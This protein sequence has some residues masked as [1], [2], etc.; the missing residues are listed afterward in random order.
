MIFVL[1]V[2]T[3][4][5][6][7]LPGL[8]LAVRERLSIWHWAALATTS[9]VGMMLVAAVV[10]I[11]I[12]RGA[13]AWLPFA[14][15]LPFIALALYAERGKTW[16][17]PA[18]EWQALIAPAV[19]LVISAYTYSRGFAYQ[20]DGS[21]DV[22]SWYNA[23]WFKHLGHVHAVANLGLPARDIFGGGEP[24]HYYWL[25]YVFP[26]AAAAINGDPAGSLYWANMLVVVS[27]WL[28]LHGLVRQTGLSAWKAAILT[29]AAWGLFG[30][31]G[32]MAWLSSGMS[33]FDFAHAIQPAGAPLVPVNLYVPQHVL[34]VS[35]LFAW[36]LLRF[37]PD[38]PES[39]PARWI[40]WA[41][42]IAA[43]TVST[44][45]GVGCLAVYGLAM[46]TTIDRK[47]APTVIGEGAIV[48]VLAI[49]VVFLL[50]VLDPSIGQSSVSSPLFI[51]PPNPNGYAV[52]IVQNLKGAL[53]ALAPAILIAAIAFY[54]WGKADGGRSNRAF[55]FALLLLVLGFLGLIVPQTVMEN[56]RL[57]REFGLRSLYLA[58]SGATIAI[59]WLLTRT[60]KN[61][62]SPVLV[63]GTLAAC[64]ALSL[65]ANL[66]N[67]VWHG[68]KGPR[69][70]T[71]I[72][73]A[74]MAALGYIAKQSA[75]D[76]MVWQYPERPEL[77][78]EGDDTWVPILAGR[79]LPASLRSTDFPKALPGILEVR[80]FFEGKDVAIPDDVDW[81][82]LSRRLHA[83]SYDQLMQK[84]SANAAWQ[85]GYCGKDACIFRRA[86]RSGSK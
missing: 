70:Y 33:A 50:H 6:L 39:R 85:K 36:A 67:I 32:T 78:N 53:D 79:P 64:L 62:F 82:Y 76:T 29:T 47:N 45:F 30:N 2:A 77:A 57:A 13:A 61:G 19:M 55:I 59:A 84:M 44:L 49:A 83:Q 66:L 25:F 35:G 21:L 72:P 60:G 12:P 41:P 28:M 37:L 15:T 68:A 3:A 86:G 58:A 81:L 10:S 1:T 40:A 46:L 71:H 18:K 11:A 24:L 75:P 22:H 17:L 74:D 52:R 8:I 63:Y 69:H 80:A 54:L 7:A 48:G 5:W 31:Q 65:P 73:A 20:P 27:F 42:L 26:G 43:G 51:N 9:M 34:M 16:H 14:T 38:G 56:M 4:I 23:D